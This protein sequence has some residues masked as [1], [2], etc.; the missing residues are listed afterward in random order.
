MLRR[1][2]RTVGSLTVTTGCAAG[3]YIAY[4][5]GLRRECQFWSFAG[6]VVAR[7]WAVQYLCDDDDD[8]AA[9]YQ[10]L[11]QEYAPLALAEILKL[12]GVLIKFGQVCSTRP[13]LVPAAYCSAFKQLQSEVPAESIETIRAIIQADLGDV[14][15]LFPEIE[16]QPCGAASIGQVRHHRH[17]AA[18]SH[19]VDRCTAQ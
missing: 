13:E 10:Q 1:A 11:H 14:D 15:L 4:D 7:Y 12:R 19:H 2:L 3:A 16:A 17:S 9:R 6:P 5:P 8:A 18:C